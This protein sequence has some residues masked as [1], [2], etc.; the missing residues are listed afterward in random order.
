MET[1]T[2]LL[3]NYTNQSTNEQEAFSVDFYQVLKNLA[4][5]LG[6]RSYSNGSTFYCPIPDLPILPIP[7]IEY[8]NLEGS[9]FGLLLG[10]SAGWLSVV[11]QGA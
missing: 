1:V 8:K 4:L 2:S 7:A 6:I 9:I 5:L 11:K 10:W 3:Y